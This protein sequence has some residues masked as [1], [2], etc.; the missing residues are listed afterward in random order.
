MLEV[1]IFTLEIFA[2]LAFV[3]IAQILGPFIS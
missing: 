3:Q 2:P 1:F